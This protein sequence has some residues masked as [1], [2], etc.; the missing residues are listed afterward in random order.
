M[1]F[2][3]PVTFPRAK[4]LRRFV[5]SI[6]LERMLLETDAPDQPDISHKGLRN[7]PAWLVKI[8]E[9]FAELRQD[10]VENIVRMTTSNAK[11]LFALS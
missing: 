10:S 8:V 11:E 3:G 6:P 4:K 1:G 9:T 2:G 7:E 5:R